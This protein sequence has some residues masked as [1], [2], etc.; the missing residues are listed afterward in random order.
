MIS[1][2]AIG[3]ALL[4]VMV[5]L[6]LVPMPERL[7]TERAFRAA[8]DCAPGTTATDCLHS[9]PAVIERTRE[10]GGKTPSHWMY[11]KTAEGDRPA[12]YFKG[13]QRSTFEGLAGKRIHVT[14][15]EGSVRYIDWAD[16]R[17]YTAAD[18][19]G[20]YR[21]FL[22]WGLAL[23]SAGLG[24]ILI[25]LWWARGYATTRLRYPWQQGIAVVGTGIL[26]LAGGLLPWLV[27]GWRAALLA[28]GV[29]GAVVAAG[30]AFAAA[31]LHRVN[32]R[33]T[34]DTVDIEPVIPADETILAGIVRG[35]VP[36]GGVLG[37]GYLMADAEGLSIIPD[38]NYRNH[39]KLIPAT[40]EPL[41]VRPPYRTDPEGLDLG[42]VCLVLECRDGDTPVY[43]AATR[44]SMPLVL[45]ALTAARQLAQK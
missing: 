28:Y 29:A 10:K 9:V 20:A 26:G 42:D 7:D 32:A 27:H 13:D 41:R 5:W 1:T 36:Y 24:L 18:P 25:G 17:W 16:A 31:V 6:L 38:P 43:V 19:R 3:T 22:A 40:L 45:G 30:C 4:L 11:V 21:P 23:G 2:T 39:P 15:W 37:G 12:L 14:Y 33:K 8:R 44:E 35:D 34:T